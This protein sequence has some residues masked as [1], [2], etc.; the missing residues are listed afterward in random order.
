LKD[1]AS[2]TETVNVVMRCRPLSTK[3]MTEGNEVAVKIDTKK[4]EIFVSKPGY[5]E[6]PK[7]FT[8]DEVFDWTIPQE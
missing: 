6:N 7:Q 2:S 1:K 5:D 8:F 4:G 3:E